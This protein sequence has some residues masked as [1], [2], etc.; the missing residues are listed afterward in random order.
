MKNNAID[1][2]GTIFEDEYCSYVYARG[3]NPELVIPF[4]ANTDDP[5]SYVERL[6]NKAN[7]LSVR[8]IGWW[9][10]GPASPRGPGPTLAAYGFEWGWKP[11]WMCLDL[12]A[13]VLEHEQ[14]AG[15]SAQIDSDLAWDVEDL[16][17]YTKGE[18]PTANESG[19]AD[20]RRR[21]HFVGRYHGAVVA[22]AVLNVTHGKRGV[23][24]VYNVGVVPAMR[25]KRFGSALMQSV[26]IAA[27]SLGLRYLTLNSAA[28]PFYIQ[29]G[30]KPMGNG[31]TWFMHARNGAF[32]CPSQSELMFATAIGR[33][34]LQSLKDQ[35]STI[36]AANLDKPLA[37]GDRPIQLTVPLHRSKM[38]AYL[39]R[40]GA[41]LDVITAWDLGM[42]HLVPR[43]LLDNPEL[44]NFRSGSH[45]G[46]P[47]HAAAIRDDVQLAQLLLSAKPDLS[48]KDTTYGGTP[49]GWAHEFDRTKIVELILASQNCLPDT[50][51]Q[52]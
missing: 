18:L 46:T 7:E 29:M 12:D 22:H 26:A 23:G 37:N 42:R 50:E 47:M 13:A 17:Y 48:I 35:K 27:K 30:Y 10:I 41:T 33:G 45:Q 28:T 19:P 11:Q 21:W 51:P 52:M 25:H 36:S 43:L 44:V 2:G 40:C 1:S 3:P 20:E 39:V 49:L 38:A 16:P 14:I 31:Q 34:D 4:P 5:S 9:S 32:A 6:L 24:G 8:S 15:F